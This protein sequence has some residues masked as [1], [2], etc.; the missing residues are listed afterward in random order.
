MAITRAQRPWLQISGLRKASEFQTRVILLWTG[1]QDEKKT[2]L[3]VTNDVP[4]VI[5]HVE[6]D[7]RTLNL[8]AAELRVAINLHD[9]GS[10]GVP[11]GGQGGV[12]VPSQGKGV[13]PD[14]LHSTSK[15]L[16][17][18]KGIMNSM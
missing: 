12:G 11:K 8:W 17:K 4:I 1:Q 7:D 6:A 15:Q 3:G 16:W 2:H 5:E 9:R 10:V 18:Q 13:L 14:V